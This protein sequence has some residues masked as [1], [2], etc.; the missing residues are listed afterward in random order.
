MGKAMKSISLGLIVL[1]LVFLTIPQEACAA[2]KTIKWRMA[3]L[4]PRG[5]SWE[6]LIHSFCE[7]VKA[8]SGG[9]LEIQE[10]YDGEGVNAPEILSACKSGLVE[11]GLPYMALHQGELPA[12]V[13]E[14]GLPGGPT[15]FSELRALFHEGGWKQVLRKAYATQ[16]LY[17]L[18]ENYQPGTYVL[19]KKP[20]N[21]IKDFQKMKIRCPGAYGKMIRNVG[22]SPVVMAFSEIY[23]AL[24]TGVID[25]AD[26]CNL[27]DHRDAKFYEVAPYIY[28]LPLTS[29]Q[30]FQAIVNMDAWKKLL[31]D[32]KA[33]LEAAAQVFATRCETH[34]IIWE[35]EAV[36]EMLSKGA[37][38]GPIPSAEDTAAWK[39][40]GKKVWP[41]YAAKDQYCKELIDLQEKFL[42]KMGQ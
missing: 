32:L 6:P 8:M 17:W 7:D 36:K 22:A 37:K 4:I 25:G 31:P 12:G 28:P 2:P 26:G 38:M 20:I 13:V 29:A 11:M 40:A 19:T 27:I 15:S 18:G 41:E 14:L 9:R 39:E 21:S 30:V 23:T 5:L 10:V 42:E 33:I 16:G 1:G 24:A 35:K 34:S 3:I